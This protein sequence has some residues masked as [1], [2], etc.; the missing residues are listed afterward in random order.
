MAKFPGDIE[1][2][3][4][5]PTG[6][7]AVVRA[8][9]DV[10]T[11]AE[12]MARAVS[13][14]G[15]ALFEVANNVYDRESIAEFTELKR[16]YDERG[17]AL[18]NS[19][20]GSIAFDPETDTYSG[21]DVDLWDKFEGS[22][23][24][25]L[26]QSKKPRVN[27]FIQKHINDSI[28]G[29]K[30]SFYKH[31]LS[32]ASKNTDAKMEA[33]YE[34][35]LG[36]N[37]LVEAEALLDSWLAIKGPGYQEEYNALIKNMPNDSIL[38]QMRMAIGKNNPQL[39][40]DLAATM[41]G[42]SADQMKYRNRLLNAASRLNT[43][44]DRVDEELTGQFSE[45]LR[46]LLEPDEGNPP[47]FEEIDASAMSVEAKDKM[48]TRLRVFDNYSEGELEEAF[49]D[50]G[51]VIADIYDRID[52]GEITTATQIKDEIGKRLH[53]DTA[54]G[55]IDDMQKPY[56]K[57]TEQMFKR[58]FGWS[59]ELGFKDDMAPFLYGKAYRE[60]K[61]E[62]KKQDAIGEK[63]TEIGRRIVRPYFIEH[64]QRT[65]PIKEDIPRI[66]ELA[67]G[68]EFEEEPLPEV[69]TEN[70]KFLETKEP[71]DEK[72]FED[73]VGRLKVTDMKKALKYYNKWQ[74]KF[75]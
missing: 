31:S 36:Q 34:N 57:D 38:Q 58:I 16:K 13:G 18:F 66:I 72:D 56:Q 20:T 8:D 47:T 26:M 33:D 27:A 63:I 68:E 22:I 61:A 2:A 21:V 5:L 44:Q 50:S 46:F 24:E 15:G 67:L 11:G 17:F 59:P 25:E 10:R 14:F 70:I 41:K 3:K 37:R 23:E 64:V 75:K 6:R 54:N 48:R 74:E 40:K 53:P 19:A 52:K 60:W 73:T 69:I 55:I 28:I 12:E 49:T 62:V 4:T 39:A 45:R 71:D 51:N 42:P 1:Y 30:E 43:Q 65:M 29:W 7:A 9:I 35:L 32:I